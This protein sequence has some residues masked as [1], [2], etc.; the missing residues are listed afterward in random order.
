MIEKPETLEK[1]IA[2]AIF[3]PGHVV[4]YKG[5]RTLTQWQ[6]DA[7]MKAI[8]DSSEVEW[9]VSCGSAAQFPNPKFLNE[10]EAISRYEKERTIDSY[11][12]EGQKRK[13]SVIK[14][15]TIVEEIRK[16]G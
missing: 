7:V 6:V 11:L 15:T 9:F 2:T 13:A 16:Y 3:D 1:K 5:E 12:Q 14:V 8:A 4:G 10:D